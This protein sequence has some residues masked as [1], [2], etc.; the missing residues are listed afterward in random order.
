MPLLIAVWVNVDAWFILGPAL[1]GLF[2]IARRIDPERATLP[3]WP[4]WLV[5]ASLAA[6]L[7]SPHHVFALTL[8]LELSPAVWGSE[9]PSDPR[10]AG[11]FA[12]PWHWS[13]LGVAGGYNLSGWAFFVLLAL[14]V[15]SFAVNRTA[16]RSWRGVVW[17]P[18]AMLAMWQARLIP[19]FAVVAGPIT[20]LNF[21]E[22]IS[23]S[24]FARPGR[25]LVLIASIALVGLAW[26]GWT[27]GFHNRDR[28]AAW[29]IY[30]D[31]TLSRVAQD[32]R[33]WREANHV[34]A[35]SHVFATHPEVGNYLAWFAPGERSFLDSRLQ[36]FTHVAG[37]FA[38][39]S[40]ALG[41]LPGG[42]S[43]SEEFRKHDIAAVLL[44]DP[45]F[46]RMTQGL[47]D[48]Q[49]WSVGR[50]EGGAV[51][52]APRG[53]AGPQFDAER[54]AFA[55]G[56]E[57]PIAEKGPATLTEP[58]P[59]W[60]QKPSR[61]RKGSWEADAART[62]LQ[63]FDESGSKS[64]ALSLLA[65]R[66]SRVGTETDPGDPVAW[67]MLGR[68]YLLLGERTWER[69]AGSA[70]TLLEH[71]RLVQ[72]TTA[73]VQAVLLNPESVHAR[74]ALTG[75]FLRRNVL[76]LAYLHAAEAL[77]LV[78]RAGPSAGETAEAFAERRDRIAA[79]VAQLEATVQTAE[80]RFLIRTAGLSG[81]PLARATIAGELGLVQKAVDVLVKSHPDLYGP[82]GLK[83][84]ADL[85]LQ[86]GQASECRVLLDRAE[87]RRNPEA[88]GVY[89]LPGKPHPGGQRWVYPLPAYDWFDLCQCA[90]VGRYLAASAAVDRI[91]GDFE[92]LEQFQIPRLTQAIAGQF[93]NEA[94]LWVPPAPVLAPLA[95]AANRASLV[96]S[97]AQAR[98]LTVA[99]A[100]LTTLA[101]VLE[102]ERGDRDEAARRFDAAIALYAS[103]KGTAPSLP[104]ES[105]AMR[106]H[107]AI[108]KQR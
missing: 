106:Y 55:G 40:R 70:L 98:F 95:S 88:L 59:W 64:P 60:E 72:L 61:G 73:L 84:L 90:A 99:R 91:C 5:P 19:F 42:D 4:W 103:R 52:L 65:V 21:R 62:F 78:R 79:L 24:A 100:D 67:F 49:R 85:L 75:V 80:N 20:A 57:L 97:L 25:G 58:R 14:G 23:A 48:T 74:E 77:R 34:P 22:V 18:F 51:L 41:V 7:L 93:R 92:K 43:G 87:L 35:E 66:A 10:F 101:G 105:L 102:L 45:D 107:D 36:L 13:P 29:A 30:T 50:V 89:P 28:G 71:I 54:A 53:T 32:L 8:P 11:V 33:G 27:N 46:G 6:C 82:G 108:R 94:V 38:G 83:L 96:E 26:F 81:D 44:Y 56:S 104:G 16:V 68:A 1:V 2:W 15:I 47:H 86:T 39:L 31:P 63:L 37:D 17:L 9:F 76:D 12:S 69:E 3:P